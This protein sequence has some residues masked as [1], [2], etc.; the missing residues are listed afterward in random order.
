MGRVLLLSLHKYADK[1]RLK[2]NI[3]DNF[4]KRSVLQVDNFKS[5]EAGEVNMH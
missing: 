3:K 5:K 1:I 2:R 4:K